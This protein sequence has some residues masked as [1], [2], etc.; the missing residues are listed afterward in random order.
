MVLAGDATTSQVH[1]RNVDLPDTRSEL[2]IPL[3]IGQRVIG[4][5]DVQ[6]KLSATF[7]EEQMDVLQTMADQVAVA[8]ENARLYTESLR[9]LTEI[10]QNRQR[11]TMQAWHNYIRNLHVDRLESTVGA[12]PVGAEQNDLR[13]LALKQGQ[14]VVGERTE[15]KTI[16]LAAPI[17]LRDQL[18]GTVEW[19]VPESDFDMN[20]VQL[21]QN[22]TDQLAVNLEKARLF[23][24]SQRAT[25]RE[26]LVNEISARLT[27]QNDI[28]QILQT[29]V[30]EVGMALRSPQV[31]IRLNS[32]AQAN[33]KSDKLGNGIGDG[34]SNGHGKPDNSGGDSQ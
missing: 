31:S 10:E 9:R 6:S 29:A 7:S 15:R 11:S 1:R 3:H 33:G 17:F 20:K 14:V 8:I 13:E 12:E 25:Q 23:Q 18:L 27:T 28:D 4:V 16:P 30:R 34:H 22:L 24:E 26:R 32:Q 5:L 21:A 19:E 2:A